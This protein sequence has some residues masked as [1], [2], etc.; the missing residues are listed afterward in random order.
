MVLSLPPAVETIIRKEGSGA[1]TIQAGGQVCRPDCSEL[2][3]SS[4][5]NIA[6]VLEALPGED[7]ICVWWETGHGIVLDSVYQAQPGE[8]VIAVFENK[9]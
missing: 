9:F 3:L 5:A 6:V 7:S 4:S 2:S 1:G 8:T